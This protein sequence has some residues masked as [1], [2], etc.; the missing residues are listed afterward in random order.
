MEAARDDDLFWSL[1]GGGNFG[2]VAAIE[3]AVSVRTR[4]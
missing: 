2:V 4:D 3:F 1:R